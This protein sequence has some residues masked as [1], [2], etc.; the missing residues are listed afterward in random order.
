MLPRPLAGAVTMSSSR[1]VRMGDLGLLLL[2]G[3]LEGEEHLACYL[4]GHD[5][6]SRV[7]DVAVVGSR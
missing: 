4:G 1:L 6:V 7:D 5:G 2:F 3:L